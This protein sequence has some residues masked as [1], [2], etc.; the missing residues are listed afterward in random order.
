[1]THEDLCERARRW[2][3]GSRKCNPVFS[4]IASC[5]EVPDA[6]GWSSCY[7]WCGSTVVE[8][9]TSR[10]DFYAD[11]R[12]YQAY[13]QHEEGLRYARTQITQKAA[14]ENGWKLI[15]LARMG[16]YRFFLCEPDVITAEL[17]ERIAPDHGLLWM[18]NAR[19][20]RTM[21][22]AV[23][24]EKLMVDTDAE[25]R[26]LR[27]A[28]INEKDRFSITSMEMTVDC[29][30]CPQFGQQGSLVP[31]AGEEPHPCDSKPK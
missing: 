3:S 15:D 16:N 21:R 7:G 19:R 5:G 18:E 14:A 9:K 8:C 10:G 24:R 6:I 13:F 12:K 27:F 30:A 31:D 22:P 2:L 11:R 20:L 25:I 29:E 26:Y 28:I 1:M 23:R 17:V 4:N